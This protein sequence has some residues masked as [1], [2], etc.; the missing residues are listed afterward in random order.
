MQPSAYT[1]VA[2]PG[3]TLIIDLLCGITSAREAAAIKFGLEELP[4]VDSV[5]FLEDGI[6]VWLLD[7]EAS[8]DIVR[9]TLVAIGIAERDIAFRNS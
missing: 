2:F 9:N 5:H 1:V 8:V 7:N 4:W 3:E 6:S